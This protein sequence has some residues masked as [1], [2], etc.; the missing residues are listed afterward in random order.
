MVRGRFKS[1]EELLAEAFRLLQEKY[2][3]Y[4]SSQFKQNYYFWEYPK[5]DREIMSMFE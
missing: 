5:C 3:E 4:E 2:Q 1:P